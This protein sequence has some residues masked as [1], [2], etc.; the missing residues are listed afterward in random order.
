M[1]I[2]RWQSVLLLI[3]CVVMAVFSFMSLGQVQLPEYT[4]NFTTLGFYIEGEPA[5]GAPSGY[6][7]HTWLFFIVSVMSAIIPLINIFMF[8]NLRLQKNLC[9]F[10]I[11]FLIAV[12]CVGCYYGFYT[13]TDAETGWSSLIVAPLLAFVATVMAYGR[14][15]SDQR[16]LAAVD[17]IR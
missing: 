13:Y 4:L 14:I 15:S 1:V 8:K 6:T 5:P 11:L 7:V 16:K 12:T 2:Q 17:R 9:L 10:E 3:A